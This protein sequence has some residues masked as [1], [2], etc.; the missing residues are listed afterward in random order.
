M[1]ISTT[2]ERTG[3]HGYVAAGA[4][5]LALWFAGIT[6]ATLL[7]EPTAS[8]V[9]IGP[10]SVTV[11]AAAAGDAVLLELYPGFARM[12]SDRAGF[13]RRLYAAGAWLV[14]PAIDGGCVSPAA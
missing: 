14:W 9:V 8:V 11:D 2:I 12:R 5:V 3:W 1:S 13:V 6:L 10:R 4:I 7:I